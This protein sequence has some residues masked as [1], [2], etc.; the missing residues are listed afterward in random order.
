MI[1]SPSLFVAAPIGLFLAASLITG[2]QEMYPVVADTVR[3][4]VTLSGNHAGEQIVLREGD[5]SRHVFFEFNDRGRGPRVEAQYVIGEAGVPNRIAITGI[6]YFK[7]KVDERFTLTGGQASWTSTAEEGNAVVST[8]AVYLALQSPPE[9]T[10]VLARALLKSP[11]HTLQLL[12]AGTATIE[13]SV[14]RSLTVGGRARS[15]RYYLIT[16]LGMTPTGLW[17]EPD[18]TL[19]ALAS[20]WTSV[21]REGWEETIPAL[22]ALQDSIDVARDRDAAVQLADHPEGPVAFTGVALFDSDRGELVENTTVLIDGNRIVGVG[23]DNHVVI[24]PGTRRIDGRG[25]TLL[26]GLWDMHA[27]TSDVDGPLN[28]G[29]GITSVRDLANTP[30]DLAER[31]KRWDSG[32]TIGPRIVKAGFIDGPGPFA[33]PTQALVTTP[34]E[35]RQWVDWYADHGY[36]QIKLYSSLKPELVSVAAQRAHARGLRLSGHIPAHM[37]ARE[38]ILQGYDE[39][40]HINMVVLNFLS[41]TLDTRTPVRFAEPGKHAVDLD[42]TSDSVRSFIQFLAERNIVVDPT[43]A[44]FEGLFTARPGKMAEGD[45]RM[46]SQLPPQLRRGLLGGGLPADEELSVQYRAS[47]LQMLA[48]VKAMHDAGVQLVAG[49]DCM[50]GFCLQRELELYS[51]AGIPNADVLRIAT[52]GAATVTGRADQLGSVRPGKLAD[53]VLIDGDPLVDMRQ[54]RRVSLVMKDGVLYDPS[55]VQRTLSITPWQTLRPTP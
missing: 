5:S 6:D 13:S 33:G 20:G 4:T 9:G 28:I 53:L 50:A 37:R 11:T 12:P 48:L 26:P 35:M 19:F 41:D 1:M 46:A 47:Y 3:Y 34:D 36:E 38:A 54:I 40:Q 15:I 52:I 14:E 31:Q 49:T 27:H 44:T 2:T 21:V 29:A 23:P 16:G 55:E 7:A 17:L 39:I 18:G 25:K 30:D 32:E 42:L 22:V 24:P 10:A 43:L 8:P 51:E 45:A